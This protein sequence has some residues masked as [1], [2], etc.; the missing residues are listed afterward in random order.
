MS[1]FDSAV[2][3]ATQTEFAVFADSVT[4]DSV[5]GRGVVT[6]NKDLMLGG[7]VQLHNA[8]SLVVLNMEF[9]NILVNSI[10]VHNGN[11]YIVAELDDVDP[12]GWRQALI[13]RS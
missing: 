3:A 11:T 5:S 4:V 12:Y 13:V 2:S 9:P 10:V 8:A 1:A 6:V 7:G